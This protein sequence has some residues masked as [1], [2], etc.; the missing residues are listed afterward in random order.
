MYM[1]LWTIQNPEVLDIIERAANMFDKVIVANV[2]P[3]ANNC[4]S[5]TKVS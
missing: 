5:G 3:R 2:I 1:K 4:F